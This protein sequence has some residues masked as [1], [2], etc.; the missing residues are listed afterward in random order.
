MDLPHM[1]ALSGISLCIFFIL[2]DPNVNM[3]DIYL[4]PVTF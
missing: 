3:G 2:G 1:I 4:L